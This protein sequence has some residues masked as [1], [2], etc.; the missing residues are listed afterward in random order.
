MNEFRKSIELTE[1]QKEEI[2]RKLY[3]K[4][5]AERNARV[6]RKFGQETAE[7]KWKR[8]QKQLQE[9]LDMEFNERNRGGY[10]R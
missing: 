4:H 3:E 1:E 5:K 10:G 9:D 8:E 6:F 7:Q 2:E